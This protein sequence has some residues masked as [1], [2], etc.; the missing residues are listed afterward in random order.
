[1]L[2][3]FTL[4]KFLPGFEG[5]NWHMLVR[6]EG[7]PSRLTLVWYKLQMYFAELYDGPSVL[8]CSYRILP[9]LWPRSHSIS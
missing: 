4:Q 8:Y 3:D 6:H 7:S 1:M 2:H 9:F 5:L